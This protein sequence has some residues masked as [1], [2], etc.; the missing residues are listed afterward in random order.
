[1]TAFDF[2]ARAHA[3]A[4]AIHESGWRAALAVTGG[5]SRAIS[6]LLETPGA[7]RTVIAAVVPYAAE[8]LADLLGGVPEQACSATTA[9]AMAM[10]ALWFARKFADAPQA[11]RLVG[12]GCT[13]SL[14]T[15][16]PKRGEHRIYV[17]AQTVRSTASLAVTLHKGRRDRAGEELIAAG[18]VLS[19]LGQTVGVAESVAF[20]GDLGL[21][22]DEPLDVDLADAT[23]AVAEV[24]GGVRRVVVFAA[25]ATAEVP[26]CAAPP[27]LVFPGAFNPPHEGHAR[28]AAIAES[29]L[30]QPLVWELSVAN[31]DKPPLDFIAIR[32]RIAALAGLVPPRPI[33]LT[34]AATFREKAAL[35]PGATFAA[36]LDTI[37]RIAE[38]RYYHG[39]AR[40]RDAAVAAL[41]AAGCRFL[42]FGRQVAGRF[43]T[44]GD[45]E[46]PAALAAL[47]TVVPA[48]EFRDDIS[49]TQI[50]T[51][52]DPL[53]D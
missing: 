23:P 27:A 10:R 40:Q 53:A 18:I 29:R 26:A 52:A 46:L 30:G 16:R 37:Q 14:V 4:A 51:S 21:E 33:A 49:S 36:G 5:G 42:V 1:M 6:T 12:V 20:G 24:A 22:R 45:L 25:G 47:C 17:A 34:H 15:E 13:A 48:A 50:R 9:R 8:A 31:V 38:P 11:E 2:E 43:Q 28:M 32:D 35:F 39:D 19:V 44:L 7:S 41:A 3:L